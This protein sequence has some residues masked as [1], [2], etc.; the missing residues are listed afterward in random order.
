MTSKRKELNC[1]LL[2]GIETGDAAAVAVVNEEKYIHHNPQAHEGSEGLAAFS[3]ES[4]SQRQSPTCLSG[5]YKLLSTGATSS[6]DR[7]PTHPGHTMVDEPTE[8]ID[9]DR[10][11]DN[12]EFVRSFVDGLSSLHSALSDPASNDGMTIQ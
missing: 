10:T 9:L 4:L 1:A 5:W 2:K 12:R 8:I 3:V 6:K 11:V 7:V